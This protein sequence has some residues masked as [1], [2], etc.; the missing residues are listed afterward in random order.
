[1]APFLWPAL[2]AL[3]SGCRPN[4]DILAQA[5]LCVGKFQRLWRNVNSPTSRALRDV[6]AIAEIGHLGYYIGLLLHTALAVPT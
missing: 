4:D 2:L 6:N 5:A 1:M 3:R